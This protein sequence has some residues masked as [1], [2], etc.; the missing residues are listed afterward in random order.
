M[1]CLMIS[2][3]DEAHMNFDFNALRAQLTPGWSTVNIVIT[4]LAFLW[5]WPLGLLMIGYIVKGA[6]FGLDLGQPSSFLP[7]FRDIGDSLREATDKFT[8]KKRTTQGT[9]ASGGRPMPDA[10]SR[11]SNSGERE[12]FESWRQRETDTIRRE[13]Q[14]LE[15]EKA[16]FEAQKRRFEESS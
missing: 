1:F 3:I 6:D 4:V 15:Q 7:F 10:D 5:F 9:T 16:E 11:G 14:A 2:N 8:S 12:A 13:R